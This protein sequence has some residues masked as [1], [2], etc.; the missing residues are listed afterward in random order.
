MQ[1][2]QNYNKNQKTVRKGGFFIRFPSGRLPRYDR[3]DRVLRT[4]RN[5][6]LFSEK[7][8]ANFTHSLYTIPCNALYVIA[9]VRGNLPEGTPCEIL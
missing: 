6:G 7:V 4:E 2:N 9:S 8:I 1:S 3:N 5:K